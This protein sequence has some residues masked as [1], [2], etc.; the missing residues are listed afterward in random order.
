MS[1]E[2]RATQPSTGGIIMISDFL[3]VLM[4]KNLVDQVK[5]YK[6]L[7]QLE[8]IFD[9]KDTIGLGKDGRIFVVLR[10]DKTENSHHLANQKGPQIITFKCQGNLEQFSNVVKQ[11]GYKVRDKLALSEHN[12]QYLFIEDF[13]ANEICLDF[14]LSE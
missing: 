7:L 2:E 3:V 9:N 12:V 6:D 14:P 11:A 1:R 4:T 10:E 8:L 13:D 5:F